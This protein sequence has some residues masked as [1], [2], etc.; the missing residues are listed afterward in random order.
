VRIHCAIG[1]QK[2]IEGRYVHTPFGEGS[3]PRFW[4]IAGWKRRGEEGTFLP[5]GSRPASEN[6]VSRRH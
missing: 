2:L 4:R 1:L 3:S 6:I 5:D